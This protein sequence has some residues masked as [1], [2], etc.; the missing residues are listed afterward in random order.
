MLFKISFIIIIIYANIQVY[1]HSPTFVAESGQLTVVDENAV[2]LSPKLSTQLVDG[3]V[4]NPALRRHRH[5]KHIVTKKQITRRIVGE[6]RR[7]PRRP[8]DAK[9]IVEKK[10]RR[11]TSANANDWTL[12]RR[13]TIATPTH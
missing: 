4:L 3:A 6:G 10:L 9:E 7:K 8:A 2:L 1:A 11:G 5:R 12:F 13:T